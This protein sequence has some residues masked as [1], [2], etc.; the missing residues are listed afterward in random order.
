MK[1]LNELILEKRE[2]KIYEKDAYLYMF[3]IYKYAHISK[4]KILESLQWLSENIE[5]LKGFEK[6]LVSID[7][8]KTA[9]TYMA[10]DDEFLDSNNISDIIKRLA[11]YIAEK[12]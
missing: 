3:N 11:D 4:D 2:N 5:V 12:L 7:E 10:S 1:S 6:F 8:T 9:W